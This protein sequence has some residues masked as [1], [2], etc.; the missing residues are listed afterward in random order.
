MASQLTGTS[1][2]RKSLFQRPPAWSSGK[3][4]EAESSEKT[5]SCFPDTRFFVIP[6]MGTQQ[7][8]EFSSWIEKGG[9]GSSRTLVT[10]LTL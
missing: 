7:G 6:E 2:G 4:V 8:W 3:A 1:G 5:L 9:P 10:V